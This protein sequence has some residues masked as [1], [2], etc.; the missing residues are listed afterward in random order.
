L[1]TTVLVVPGT[2]RALVLAGRRRPSLIAAALRVQGIEAEVAAAP[3]PASYD[4]F[5]LVVLL[6]DAPLK[7][8]EER[9]EALVEFVGRRGGGLLAVGGT[10]G[11]GLARL[12]ESPLAYLVPLAVPPRAAPPSPPAR[13]RGP[14]PHI[15]IVDEEREAWPITLCLLVDRSGSMA[16]D[17]KLGRALR[18]AAAAARALTPQDRVAVIVFGD[19]ARVA[20]PPRAA[21]DPAAVLRE[22]RG[23]RA[24]GNTAMFAALELGGAILRREKSAIRHM[25]L[26]TDGVAT[27]RGPWHDLVKRMFRDGITVS[28]LEIL[29]TR[30]DARKLAAR[31]ADWGGGRWY[32]AKDLREI[33]QIITQDTK[34]ILQERRR[35]GKDAER[36]APPKE[37]A[38]PPR[39][40]P[41]RQPER[42]PEPPRPVALVADPAAPRDA[43]RG[44]PD[45]RLPRVA[46]FE[47]GEPRFASWTAARAGRDGPP[48][49]VYHRVGL[50]TAAAL[51]FDPESPLNAALRDHP[52]LTRML[53]QL[54]RSLLPDVGR[55]PWSLETEVTEADGG[56][57]RLVVRGEDGQPRTDLRLEIGVSR[58]DGEERRP[59]VLRRADSY[60]TP[61]PPGGGLVRVT[62]RAPDAPGFSDRTFLV[63]APPPAELHRTGPDPDLLLALVGGDPARLD[64]PPREVL[65]QPRS[66]ASG[67]RP[68]RLPFLLLAAILLPLD[69]WARRRTDSASP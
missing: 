46:G 39:E 19:R 5:D 15:E 29:G 54:A 9:H 40:P 12:S 6:P 2:P 8:L 37:P 17:D 47:E 14:D 56:R 35:R 30:W 61:L 31:I 67:R 7:R 55:D 36:R 25:V 68:L 59:S 45:D 48:V 23:L 51:A 50:G 20:L 52:D 44:I 65:R 49:L 58:P 60:E 38:Q 22:L 4:A 64:P 11:P 34:R 28:T 21:G 16:E 63:A 3:G 66:A 26:V 32:M 62:V 57:L 18:S 43:L 27:D 42:K 13:G 1:A 33:P 41:P 24:E 10:E 69:A 53:A